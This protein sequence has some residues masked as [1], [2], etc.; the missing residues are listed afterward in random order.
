MTAATDVA[1]V[2][3]DPRPRIVE[4]SGRWMVAG[5]RCVACG[6]ALVRP[7]PRCIRCRGRVEPERFRSEGRIW[8]TTVVH[9]A[10]E[11]GGEAPYRLAYVDLDA[12][13]RVLLRLEPAD[14]PAAIGDRVRL[15]APSAAGN[16]AGEIVG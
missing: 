1:H 16:P 13:P 7:V 4:D 15:T 3:G 11:P 10:A 14:V 2:P 9:V 8:A 5:A 6:H 12:G